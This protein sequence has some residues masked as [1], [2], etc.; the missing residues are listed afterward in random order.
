MPL[1]LA[2][3]VL[4]VAWLVWTA[5][6]KGFERT[7]PGATFLLMLFP[8]ECQI[9]VPGLSDLDAQ[10]VIVI[11]LL[12]LQFV[13]PDKKDTVGG[14]S[15]LSLKWL[16][17]LQIVW[18]GV[19]TINS[20]VVVISVK[21]V[22]SQILD[23]MVVYWIYARN[24]RRGETV[25]G[26]LGGYVSALIALSVIGI[27]EVYQ[28]WS[29]VAL[30]PTVAHHFGAADVD[31]RAGRIQ[32]TFGHPILFGLALAMAIPAALCLTSLAKDKR[33]KWFFGLGILPMFLC[34]YKTGSRG[35]WIALFMSLCLLALLGD[36][37]IRKKLGGIAVLVLVVLVVRPGVFDTLHN[38]YAGSKD[39]D[40][41]MGE[42]YQWR[43]VLYGLVPVELN[44]SIGRALWGH[45]PNSFYYLGIKTAAQVDGEIHIVPVE[46]CDSAVVLLLIET[47][48]LGFAI[49]MLPLLTVWRTAL[50]GCVRS[51]GLDRLIPLTFFCMLCAYFFLMT[52]VQN[53][54][55][56]QQSYMLWIVMAM[57]ML[58][59][60]LLRA[61]EDMP[62]TIV[63]KKR[64]LRSPW[65]SDLAW[66][67]VEE[68]ASSLPGVSA[69]HS[70]VR[71]SNFQTENNRA[72]QYN[73]E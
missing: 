1:V 36:S 27:A 52:N 67:C 17:I 39:S 73:T 28:D 8:V 62:E 58:N 38:I 15:Y 25:R 21:A 45:G 63:E 41:A 10:R 33:E 6:T 22:I 44:H 42:S 26:I 56:G 4:I 20:A 9:A 12:V 24:I 64:K 3:D 34:I 47:G 60:A 50:L 43:Y 31:D 55:W 23:F 46:S 13:F 65:T 51:T 59:P 18:L 40:S 53:Y 48:Y 30:F 19:A 32:S 71:W 16:L 54:G 7:L 35:P 57:A 37:T 69:L 68:S 66:E 70:P 49:A 29:P 61:E 5:A 14:R 72:S 2:I 11:T